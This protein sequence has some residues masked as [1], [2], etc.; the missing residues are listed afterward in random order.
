MATVQAYHGRVSRQQ[1]YEAPGKILPLVDS[2]LLQ[3][4]SRINSNDASVLASSFTEGIAVLVS[5]DCIKQ[6]VFC[7]TNVP[8]PSGKTR[9]AAKDDH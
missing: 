1:T 3:G 9:L 2:M 7:E 8:Q 6:H 5:V 4:W